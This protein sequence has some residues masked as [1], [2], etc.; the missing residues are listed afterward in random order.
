VQL[1]WAERELMEA[2]R[3][4]RTRRYTLKSRGEAWNVDLAGAY[5]VQAAL[6]AGPVKGYKLGL[7]SPAKQAQ[8]GITSPIWGRLPARMLPDGSVSLQ[9]FLQP[10]VE[11]EVAVVLRDPVG[12]DAT[13]GAAWSAVAGFVLCADVLDSVWEGYRFTAAEVVADNASGGACLLGERLLA[14]DQLQGSLRLYLN[15]R[16]AAEGPVASL[17]DPALQL[18][19][20]ARQTGGLA[21]GQVVPLGSPASAVP[22]EPGLVE[23]ALGDTCLVCQVQA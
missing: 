22:L 6:Q 5:R 9:A 1:S 7:I 15:G 17:G 4:A 11:P 20:L 23:V 16:L 13:P 18:C 2:I 3:D 12:P 8:M 21:P 19:W 10:R 14:P